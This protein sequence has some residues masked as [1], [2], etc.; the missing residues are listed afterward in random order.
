MLRLIFF[1]SSQASSSIA[2]TGEIGIAFCTE[3][4][5]PQ[6]AYEQPGFFRRTSTARPM[7]EAT[8]IYESDG[9]EESEEY[10]D[11]D[12][13]VTSER[14][15]MEMAHNLSGT[16]STTNSA[17]RSVES[18]SQAFQAGHGME[19]ILIRDAVRSQEQ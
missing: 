16:S 6:P 13:E 9:E 19:H 10:S 5:T 11:S 8:E 2:V 18:V 7:S 14:E 4:Y 17:R 1:L 3:K 15:E 12:Q